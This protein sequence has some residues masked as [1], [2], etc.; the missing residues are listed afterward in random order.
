MRKDS[1]LISDNP[2]FCRVI[3][4]NTVVSTPLNTALWSIWNVGD[5]QTDD[6]FFADFNT[7]GSGVS[8]VNS[9]SRAN[10][11]AELS[12]S[13]AAAYSISSAVGSDY[14]SWVDASYIV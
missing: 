11:S 2:N 6:V 10:F 12:T 8:G 4:K 7:T 9:A 3:F 14:T 13:Q 5:P 1:H